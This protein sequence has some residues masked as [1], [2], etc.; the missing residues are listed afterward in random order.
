L[1]YFATENLPN[2]G[3][4]TNRS[5]PSPALASLTRRNTTLEDWELGATIMVGYWSG[6]RF[7]KCHLTTSTLTQRRCR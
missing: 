2:H 1:R 3:T 5:C 6:G 7:S 4:R